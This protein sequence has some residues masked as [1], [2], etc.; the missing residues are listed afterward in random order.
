MA[1]AFVM[2][3]LP[4]KTEAARR[5]TRELLGPRK[6]EYDDLQRR[7]GVTRG[8]Y[9]LQPG[10]EGDLMIVVGEGT[11]A[12]PSSFPDVAG[13]PFD[14]W[15]VEQVQDIAGVDMLEM[16]EEMPELLGEWRP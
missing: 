11:F 14:R 12:P 16:D 9:Y 3:I 5:L 13:N 6:R 1:Y 8:S 15:F 7:Q 10:P 2:P 4:G